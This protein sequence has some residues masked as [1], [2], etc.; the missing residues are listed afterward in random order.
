V[1]HQ[2]RR[3]SA[4]YGFGDRGLLAPGML[5]DV[6]MIDYDALALHRPRMAYDLPAGGK[7][8]VQGAHG[9][10]HTIVAGVETYADGEPTDALPGRLVRGPQPEAAR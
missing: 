9:Y 8:L 1:H 6:N 3:T 4:L 7:R 5:A 2:T 10:L